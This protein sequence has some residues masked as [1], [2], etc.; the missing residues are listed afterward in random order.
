MGKRPRD[1]QN[2]KIFAV[3]TALRASIKPSDYDLTH[4]T[5]T[6]VKSVWYSRRDRAVSGS[7]WVERTSTAGRC[8][9][10]RGR[11]R[12]GRS[13]CDQLGVLHALAH[14]IAD[15]EVAASRG[16]VE[17]WHGRTFAR[18]FLELVKHQWGD[19]RA[20]EMREL[21]QTHR[22]KRIA[23]SEATRA[24]RRESWE[25]REAEKAKELWGEWLRK[26]ASE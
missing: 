15:G 21:Y 26:K 3:E 17:A 24:K 10:E 19:T 4:W 22:V 13:R 12:L 14:R 2:A 16:E 8:T 25:L 20:K 7:L 11:L 1:S 18:A 9:I 23:V 6:F 5:Q